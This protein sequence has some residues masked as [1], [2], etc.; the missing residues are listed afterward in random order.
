MNWSCWNNIIGFRIFIKDYQIF[1]SLTHIVWG[2]TTLEKYFFSLSEWKSVVSRSLNKNSFPVGRNQ[3]WKLLF[4]LTIDS[5]ECSLFI[6]RVWISTHT[7][8][9]YFRINR[10]LF[11]FLSENENAIS[12]HCNTRH[13]L[14]EKNANKTLNN[15]FLVSWSICCYTL[16]KSERIQGMISSKSCVTHIEES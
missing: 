6:G 3:C 16:Q 12:I 10:Y 15:S 8:M 7:V 1:I 13:F 11:G 14:W 9:I 2:C 4:R 5:F